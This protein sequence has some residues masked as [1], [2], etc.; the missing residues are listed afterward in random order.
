MAKRDNQT[1]TIKD[2]ARHSEVSIATVS[3]VVNRA[4]WVPTETRVRVQRIIDALG[5]RPNRLARGLKTRQSYTIGAIVSDIAN[6]FFT[7]LI[8]SLSHALYPHDRNVV[9]CDSNHRFELGSRNF[10]MLLE[11][12]VDAMVLVGDSVGRDELEA[13]LSRGTHIPIVAIERD[14]ALDMVNTLLIDSEEGAF[15]ATMHLV[16]QGYSRIAMISGP[17]S[18]PGSG[19]YGQLQFELGY[20]RALKTA[21]LPFRKRLVAEGDFRHTGGSEAMRRFMALT[22]PPDAVFAAN[23]IMALG[24]MQVAH[25]LGLRIPH[26]VAIVGYDD[27]PMAVQAFPPLTTLASPH[28]E[29]AQATA[30]LLMEA[31][32][33]PAG[34]RPIRQTFSVK[35]IER[36][37]SVLTFS[38]GNSEAVPSIP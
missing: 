28:R 13:Y 34:Y 15:Q 3:A 37:S 26:D 22:T 12:Q 24:A 29:I 31:F 4:D 32:S 23:D 7:D 35:L 33:D 36:G 17:F 1:P 8:R 16:E 30:S 20:R 5:Y 18:G 9:L 25:E 19:T 27:I 38:P 11:K 2:V 21:G 10:W 6:P 14:Y